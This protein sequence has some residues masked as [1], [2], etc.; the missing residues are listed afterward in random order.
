MKKI[1]K[2]ILTLSLTFSMI[3]SAGYLFAN[4]PDE[5]EQKKSKKNAKS[6]ESEIQKIIEDRKKVSNCIEDFNDASLD[7]LMK[8]KLIIHD[9]KGYKYNGKGKNKKEDYKITF[10]SV[11]KINDSTYLA[12]SS[13]DVY[14]M[15]STVDV[16]TKGSGRKN[17]FECTISPKMSV[18]VRPDTPEEIAEKL[19]KQLRLDKES[20]LQE[21][22]AYKN[23][24]AN[25]VDLSEYFTNAKALITNAETSEEVLEI[26][27]SV[28]TAMKEMVG[29]AISVIELAKKVISE[30]EASNFVD[31]YANLLK[32][33]VRKANNTQ[34]II[35]LFMND[36][37]EIGVSTLISGNKTETIANYLKNLSVIAKNT[38]KNNVEFDINIENIDLFGE[39]AIVK[40]IQYFDGNGVYCDVTTKSIELVKQNEKVAIN[41]IEVIETKSCK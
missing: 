33:Y 16:I 27:S 2:N 23:N 26:K 40:V 17:K 34:E 6:I 10:E 15:K 31:N 32:E 39:K 25:I 1:V 5:T 35:T 38:Y 14:T 29:E 8:D 18:V 30:E 28:L 13:F 7:L 41:K 20:S 19:E 36:T 9:E 24:S 22:E 11:E 4:N 21:L 12:I 37:C 3:V